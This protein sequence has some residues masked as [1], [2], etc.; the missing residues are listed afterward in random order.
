MEESGPPEP[1][2]AKAPARIMRPPRTWSTDFT[3]PPRDAT[4][5]L[6]TWTELR[7]AR[8]EKGRRFVDGKWTPLSLANPRICGAC[9][10]AMEAKR[11]ADSTCLPQAESLP[12]DGQTNNACAQKSG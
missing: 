12:D 11:Y 1:A 7:N 10:L 6:H 3:V 2:P 8:T 9:T 4:Q 5:F